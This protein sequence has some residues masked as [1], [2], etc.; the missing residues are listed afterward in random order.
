MKIMNLTHSDFLK[1][2]FLFVLA[3]IKEKYIGCVER[4]IFHVFFF[5][6]VTN[7]RKER[8]KRKDIENGINIKA[9]FEGGKKSL[10]TRRY[11]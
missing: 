10:Y 5:C 7:E 11:S 9:V 2:F 4:N 3:K 8:G 1:L 6:V